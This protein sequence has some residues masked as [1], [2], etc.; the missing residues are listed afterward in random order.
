MTSTQTIEPK[1]RKS[2]TSPGRPRSFDEATA[3]TAALEV[4]WRQGYEATSLDDLTAAMGIS[5]SSFYGAFGSKL[6]VLTAALKM[7]SD[8]N[9]TRLQEIA[10]TATDD[11]LGAM[12]NALTG[13]EAGQKGCLLVNCITE[14]APHQE[15]VAALGRRHLEEIER[16]LAGTIDPK[17]PHA[18]LDKARALSALTIGTLAMR[19]SGFP[20]EK[21][22]R[23]LK[24]ARTILSP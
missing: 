2:G 13:L 9:L 24:E 17:N 10:S 3:L 21:I 6:A 16:I 18:A 7:Y 20:P 14:M 11:P 1:T 22:A 19:K 8:A 23:S 15:E 4:F 12:L 5:R